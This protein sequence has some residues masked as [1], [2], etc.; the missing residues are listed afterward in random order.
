MT[1]YE[2]THFKK[3]GTGLK[4]QITI[5]L[6]KVFPTSH[7]SMAKSYITFIFIKTMSHD[8]LVQMAYSHILLMS[9]SKK[10]AYLLHGF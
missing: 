8:V 7:F 10:Y 9:S 5:I 2:L 1:S 3:N 6:F 4:N